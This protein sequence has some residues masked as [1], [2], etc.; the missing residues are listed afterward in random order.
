M[1]VGVRRGCGCGVAHQFPAFV[2][3]QVA[4]NTS[5]PITPITIRGARTLMSPRGFPS[6]GWGK[7][8]LNI[9]PAV[10]TAVSDSEHVGGRWGLRG[11]SECYAHCD[12]ERPVMRARVWGSC[13][14]L[15]VPACT[16]VRV[17]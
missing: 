9:H 4:S 12:V 16:A 8:V 1:V 17:C 11:C 2:S 14:V 3:E 7:V 5:A 10:E 6:M 13:G 15:C